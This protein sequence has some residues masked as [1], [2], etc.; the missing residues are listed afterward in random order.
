MLQRCHAREGQVGVGGDEGAGGA[1]AP[2][3]AVQIVDQGVGA[4]GEAVA[5]LEA[6]VAGAGQHR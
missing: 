2:G 4:V 1:L 6:A 3:A 5:G